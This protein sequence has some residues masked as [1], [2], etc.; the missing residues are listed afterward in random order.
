MLVKLHEHPVS[1]QWR[2][3][4]PLWLVKQK[5]RLYVQWTD[6]SSCLLAHMIP[7]DF[8]LVLE[9]FCWALEPFL[10]SAG[11]V[12]WSVNYNRNVT[13]SDGSGGGVDGDNV[14]TFTNQQVHLKAANANYEETFS[15]QLS[16]ALIIT[17]RRETDLYII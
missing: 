2:K 17:P 13:A 9:G 5:I 8:F 10:I 7:L 14:G 12:S 4:R 1:G 6:G 15:A 11:F 16:K 3:Q